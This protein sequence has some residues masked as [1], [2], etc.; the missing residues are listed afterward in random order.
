[1][2]SRL[3]GWKYMWKCWLGKCEDLTWSYELSNR[4]CWAGFQP[5]AWKE[6]N[7]QEKKWRK[8]QWRASRKT[9]CLAKEDSAASRKRKICRAG[10]SLSLESWTSAWRGLQTQRGKHRRES[11]LREKVEE[12]KCEINTFSHHCS[13]S[14]EKLS[15]DRN[16]RGRDTAEDRQK[17]LMLR[18]PLEGHLWQKHAEEEIKHRSLCKRKADKESG[19]KTLMGRNRT[20]S[21]LPREE[22][23][24]GR[25]RWCWSEIKH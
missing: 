3:R 12:R 8:P 11:N 15:E 7:L 16:E 20:S 6:E 5:E 10:G 4:C 13:L 9:S 1:M 14:E 23:E 19:W 18:Q 21:P 17:K 2:K 22:I 24:G 25:W